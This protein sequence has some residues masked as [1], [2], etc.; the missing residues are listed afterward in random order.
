[1]NQI[2][3]TLSVFALLMLMVGFSSCINEVNSKESYLKEYKSFIEEVNVNKNKYSEEEWKKKDEVF[4]TF[5]EELYGKYQDELRLLEQARIAKY[6]LQYGSI[7]GIKAL[8]NALES[9][10]VED[11]IEEITNL[12]DEDIQKDLDNLMEDLKEIWDEDLKDDLKGKLNELKMKL[13]DEKFREAITN[14]IEEIE[15]IVN[16]EDIQ[17]KIKDISKELN[18]LL[19]E[20]EKKV[21]KQILIEMIRSVKFGR[22]LYAIKYMLDDFLRIINITIETKTDKVFEGIL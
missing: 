7:R 5:S 11:A 15:A 17:K 22:R 12:F 3:L 19:K 4:S 1:M 8:N 18:E 10:E 6:A 9:G 2:K 13:E 14:K 16:D 20:I 21:E